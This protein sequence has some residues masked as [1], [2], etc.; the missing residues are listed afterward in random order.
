MLGLLSDAPAST[1]KRVSPPRS[2]ARGLDGD[3]MAFPIEAQYGILLGFTNERSV[4]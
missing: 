2:Q 3:R 4:D 1:G